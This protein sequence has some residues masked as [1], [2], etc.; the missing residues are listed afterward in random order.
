MS[1]ELKADVTWR[2]T[3]PECAPGTDGVAIIDGRII[4]R[5]R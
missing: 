5:V 3:F 1:E 4:G 2:R